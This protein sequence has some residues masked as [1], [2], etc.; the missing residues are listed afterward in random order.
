MSNQDDIFFALHRVRN[1]ILLPPC[2]G[3]REQKTR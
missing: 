2:G 1:L 3:A